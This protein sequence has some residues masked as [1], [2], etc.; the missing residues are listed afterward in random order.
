MK[1]QGSTHEWIPS[2]EHNVDLLVSQDFLAHYKTYL[3]LKI[4]DDLEQSVS[5]SQ[6]ERVMRI[7]LDNSYIISP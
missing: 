1:K 3:C 4:S 7:S 2:L 5:R 6:R